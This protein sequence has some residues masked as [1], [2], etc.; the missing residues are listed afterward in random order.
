MSNSITYKSLYEQVLQEIEKRTSYNTKSSYNNSSQL[1]RTLVSSFDTSRTDVTVAELVNALK[2]TLEEAI[3][4]YISEGLVVTATSPISS[5]V[6]VSAGKGSIGGSLYTLDDDL[7]LNI[8]LDDT[9]EVFYIT[10]YKDNIRVERTYDYRKLTIAKIV[11]PKPGVTSLIQD[12][13]DEGW[14]AYIVNF[15]EYK[16]YGRNDKFEED[17]IEL[18]RDNI[19]P[20]LA[21]NL[22]GNIRLSEDL[23]I[24][25]TQGTLELDS[26]ELRLL[27]T[28]DVTMAK[29]NRNGTFFYDSNGIEIARFTTSDARIGNI[30]VTKS[31][32]GSAN[33][34]SEVRGFRIE[35]SGYA[36][37]GDVRVRGRISSSVFEYDK[38]SAV[39][40]KLH[41]SNSSVLAEDV[42]SSDTT[43]TVE[44]S[45]FTMSEIV[46][47]KSGSDQEYME[48]T[49]TTNAPT[50]S[51]SRYL[52]G[53]SGETNP[54]WNKGTAIVSTGK[55]NTGYISLDAASNYS[56]FIDIVLRNSSTYDDITT[57]ARLGNLSGITDDLYGILSGYGLYS[58]NVYLRGKLYAPDIKTAITGSRVE[59]STTS[60]KAYDD[61]NIAIFQVLMDTEIGI[62]DIGDIIIGD[63]DG[64][65]L[66]WDNSEGT[67]TFNGSG[68]GG[69]TNLS[70]R[71]FVSN[72][73]F[74]AT[75]YNTA[76]WSSGSIIFSDGTTLNILSGDTGNISETTYIYYDNDVSTTVLQTTTTYSNAIGENKLLL[77]TIEEAESNQNQVV[78][79]L[80]RLRGT[81]ISG[82][83]ITTG[84]I[85]ASRIAAGTITGDKIAANTIS[86]NKLSVD[87]LSA[88]TADLGSITAGTIT[89]GLI[90]TA[91]SGRRIVLEP[92]GLFMYDED[93]IRKFAVFNESI[94]SSEDEGDVIIGNIGGDNYMKWDESLS[95]LT[96]KGTINAT[97][98]NFTGTVNVGTAGRVYIDGANE[99]IKVYDASSNL[100]V[101]LGKLS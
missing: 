20:V 52:N 16:L 96:V 89:G 11:V 85:T 55:T 87:E 76:S 25:N 53:A 43:I 71:N 13:K 70:D 69:T 30:L 32:I 98:G 28:D 99:V 46:V 33:F 51:V 88:I 19:S 54:S 82:N 15:T 64:D 68:G 6:N 34:Q 9:S 40:G 72:I 37:F 56:P 100:R 47:I 23:K 95:A 5:N 81:T 27:S 92:D 24:I 35:D 8:P 73:V 36:E 83:S 3:P 61:S 90:Q 21:D 75:D 86:A 58:D 60:F 49:N 94:S 41:I 57:K 42:S 63:P 80:N 7:A 78:I 29:F 10:L 50:Y 97:S 91:I 26:S 2:D 17:T 84:T 22:I 93:G 101:K 59:L 67:L 66:I 31:N 65:Y 44:D 18:L 1:D 45:V 62:G 79:N 74:T 14:N 4:Q 77:A 39:G 12:D 48:I 38:I